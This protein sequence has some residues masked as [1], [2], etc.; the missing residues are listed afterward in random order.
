[1]P[2]RRCN[3][4]CRSVATDSQIPATRHRLSPR[5]MTAAPIMAPLGAMC[6]L[7]VR[8]ELRLCRLGFD[9][10]QRAVCPSPPKDFIADRGQDYERIVTYAIVELEVSRVRQADWQLYRV[11]LFAQASRVFTLTP[12]LEDCLDL[13]AEACRAAWALISCARSERKQRSQSPRTRCPR[14][15]VS[16]G[17]PANRQHVLISVFVQLPPQERRRLQ[18]RCLIRGGRSVAHPHSAPVLPADRANAIAN[19][20]LH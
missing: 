17:A 6:A 5:W 12:P 3:V 14:L 1:M 4:V 9:A 7:S 15:L 19:Y 13:R 16:K 18:R 20:L 10:N 2:S 11:H 8:V